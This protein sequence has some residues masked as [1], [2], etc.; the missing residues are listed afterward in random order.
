MFSFGYKMEISKADITK[1]ETWEALSSILD[2]IHHFKESAYYSHNFTIKP[3]KYVIKA[4]KSI[5]K[6][7]ECEEMKDSLNNHHNLPDKKRIKI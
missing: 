7:I 5:P 1:D 2:R 3:L 4:I 6:V